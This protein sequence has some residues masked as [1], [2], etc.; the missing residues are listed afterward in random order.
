MPFRKL[1]HRRTDFNEMLYKIHRQMY[2]EYYARKDEK[3]KK[4]LRNMV[5]GHAMI[6]N[7]F[8]SKNIDVSWGDYH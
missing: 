4:A 8:R 1:Y 7:M 3:T 6:M 2:P 5:L